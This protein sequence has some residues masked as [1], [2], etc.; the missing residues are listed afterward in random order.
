V[1]T[2]ENGRLAVECDGADFASTP[3][4]ARSDIERERELRR[5]GWEFVRV[6][7][8]VFLT[9]AD[10]AMSVVLAALDR[11]GVQPLTLQRALTVGEKAADGTVEVWE[12]VGLDIDTE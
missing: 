11:R 3:E 7:E 12:P 9:D 5:C 10:A 8:S 6:R 1:V 2:G 4:Q